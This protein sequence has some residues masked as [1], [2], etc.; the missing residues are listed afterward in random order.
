MDEDFGMRA[1]KEYRQLAAQIQEASATMKALQ[2]KLDRVAAV[3][4]AYGL[5]AELDRL[6]PGDNWKA[7]DAASKSKGEQIANETARFLREG[8]N[9]WIRT[10]DIYSRLLECGIS[11]G[12]K[13]PNS[14]LSAHLSNSKMF[15]SDRARGWRLKPKFVGGPARSD[16]QKK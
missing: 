7:G 4:Q 16:A 3:I 2:P 1:V 13:N 14:T 12:G 11:I 5:E 6:E 8:G 15:E 10:S 9:Y